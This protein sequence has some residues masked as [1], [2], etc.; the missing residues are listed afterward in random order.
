MK[1]KFKEYAEMF[2]GLSKNEVIAK[3]K[4]VECVVKEYVESPLRHIPMYIEVVT[5]EGRPLKLWFAK[6]SRRIQVVM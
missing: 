5:S 2:T 3:A 4:E 6:K 1:M